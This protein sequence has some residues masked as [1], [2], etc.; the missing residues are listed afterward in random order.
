MRTL[1]RP[2]S[3]E[4]QSPFCKAKDI[5]MT[6]G[7]RNTKS[8]PIAPRITTADDVLFELHDVF[9]RAYAGVLALQAGGNT[10]VYSCGGSEA[11]K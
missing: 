9:C 6:S 10:P 5:H 8:P 4:T 3:S 1:A 7:K 11:S 2:R